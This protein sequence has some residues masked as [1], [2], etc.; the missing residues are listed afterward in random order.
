MLTL[1]LKDTERNDGRAN[2]PY[3][4]SS[5]LKKILGYMEQ[6]TPPNSPK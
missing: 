2:K 1:Y 3:L 6:K 4:M 5:D